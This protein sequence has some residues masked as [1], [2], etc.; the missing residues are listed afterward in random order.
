MYSLG[1]LTA[2]DC[3]LW[4]TRIEAILH[5]SST[6]ARRPGMSAKPMKKRAKRSDDM[7]S[8]YDFRDGVRG[9]YVSR[10][11]QGK[12]VMVSAVPK[13]KKDSRRTK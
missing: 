10:Y 9:K 8:E 5:A 6:H 4:L 2:A 1:H 11:R 7:R 13:G 12:K 3:W